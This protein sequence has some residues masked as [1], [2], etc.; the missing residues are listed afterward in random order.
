MKFLRLI[1]ICDHQWH[2]AR[3]PDNQAHKTCAKWFGMMNQL[4]KHNNGPT[5]VPFNMILIDILV[6]KSSIFNFSIHNQIVS[7]SLLHE[8]CGESCVMIKYQTHS[9]LCSDNQKQVF[10]SFSLIFYGF[11]FRFF[12]ALYPDFVRCVLIEMIANAFSHNSDCYSNQ[13]A[14]QW[15]K[16][17]LSCGVQHH[18]RRPMAVSHRA[19][20]IGSMKFNGTHGEQT[21]HQKLVIIRR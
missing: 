9:D 12:F 16:T 7:L 13:I 5:N 2:R 21:G 4:P 6:C 20:K 17:Q 19:S 8:K 11:F 1:I 10:F 15:V 14:S 3:W 18:F